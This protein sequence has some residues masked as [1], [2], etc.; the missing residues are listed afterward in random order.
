MYI[1]HVETFSRCDKV[2][3]E[4]GECRAITAVSI[5]TVVVV[6]V[7][8]AYTSTSCVSSNPRLLVHFGRDV[9]P[10]VRYGALYTIGQLCLD[11]GGDNVP[12]STVFGKFE[13]ALRIGNA[14]R[15]IEHN[16]N[17]SLDYIL[18]FT[19]ISRK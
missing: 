10:R 8:A 11:F 15:H 3:K 9:H 5:D 1:T 17:D 19:C 13:I 12:M 18:F 16:K 4:G 14:Q 7:V 6:V 2:R